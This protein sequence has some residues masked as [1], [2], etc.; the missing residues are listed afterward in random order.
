MNL[1]FFYNPKAGATYNASLHQEIADILGDNHTANFI[2]IDDLGKVDKEVPYDVVIAIGGDGTVNSVAECCCTH[3]KPMAIIPRGSGDGLARHLKLPRD[4]NKALDVV[5]SG[6]ITK[7]DTALLNDHFFVNVAGS[8]FE[9]IVAHE[10]GKG[11]RGL[12]GYIKAIRKHYRS[13]QEQEITLKTDREEIKTKYFSLSIAN[14][15]QWGN[16]F[17]IA[18]SASM[19][20]GVLEIAIMDK[21]KWFQIPRLLAY[22]NGSQQKDLS[23]IHY[24]KASSLEILNQEEH[25]HLDGEPLLMS[26]DVNLKMQAQS[27]Q[28]LTAHG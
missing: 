26:K 16:N 27:L 3:N 22:L 17:E 14:G 21:P 5:L 1:L 8:G 11:T 9:A 20:D 4:L 2:H 13:Y 7:I 24:H 28:V 15:S 25:W 23:F 12:K 10:F 19:T 6:N 18:S